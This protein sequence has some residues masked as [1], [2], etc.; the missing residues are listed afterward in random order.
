MSPDAVFFPFPEVASYKL[1]NHRLQHLEVDGLFR[2]PWPNQRDANTCRWASSYAPS[3]TT[4]VVHLCWDP[5]PSL[6]RIGQH[7]CLCQVLGWSP[8]WP[9]SAL[10]GVC[11]FSLWVSA[12]RS[13][14]LPQPK[15]AAPGLQSSSRAALS[16]QLG[17]DVH[18]RLAQ[19]LE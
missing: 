14:L 10:C 5:G 15:H 2:G 4:G 11:V 6:W 12:R 19:A 18:V 9:G 8:G 3:F 1:Y 13:D 16:L 7:S 17:E